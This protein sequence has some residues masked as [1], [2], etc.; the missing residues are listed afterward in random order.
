MFKI[1]FNIGLNKEV[2]IKIRRDIILLDLMIYQKLLRNFMFHISILFL[3]I[4]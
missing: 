3:K 4:E 2:K 1:K